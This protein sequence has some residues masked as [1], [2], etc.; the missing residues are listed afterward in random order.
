MT[1]SPSVR[2]SAGRMTEAQAWREIARRIADG[3]SRMPFGLC[4]EL[5]DLFSRINGTTLPIYEDSGL[6]TKMYK[7]CEEHVRAMGFAGT[8][9]AFPAGKERESRILAALL[10]ALEAEDDS[11]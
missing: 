11:R 1:L 6:Y 10:F 5:A 2:P 7:R 4:R 8:A 9:V 3:E